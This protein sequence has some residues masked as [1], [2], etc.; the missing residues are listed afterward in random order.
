[1]WKELLPLRAAFKLEPRCLHGRQRQKLT[2]YAI[3]AAMVCQ[4]PFASLVREMIDWPP[5]AA[6]GIGSRGDAFGT[7][8]NA[9]LAN[10]SGMTAAYWT[11]ALNGL[12]GR[13]D[14]KS[15]TWQPFASVLNDPDALIDPSRR[16]CPACLQLDLDSGVV[17]Y[18]R[19]LWTIRV[20]R[21]CPEHGQTLI[22]T[23][24]HC[25]YR[26][27]SEMSRRAV[28]GMCWRCNEWLG[29]VAVQPSSREDGR[30]TNREIWVAEQI[31]ALLELDGQQTSKV[32]A[33]SVPIMLDCGVSTFCDGNAARFAK[34]VQRSASSLSEWRAGKVIPSLPTLIELA[35]ACDVSLR[36]WF[37]GD[38]VAWQS[39]V[40][41]HLGR[42]EWSKKRMVRASIVQRDWVSI[43]ARIRQ[44]VAVDHGRVVSWRTVAR[45][46]GVDQC[47]L[48]RRFP[49]EAEVISK[50]FVAYRSN[51]A[52]Q[53]RTA[54]REHLLN[55]F[56]AA[57]SELIASGER[58]TRR[59]IQKK[60]TC[61][62][63]Q[64]RRSDYSWIQEQLRQRQ[65]ITDYQRSGLR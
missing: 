47:E 18:E 53:R 2:D 62:G 14:L 39:A 34:L 28:S 50:R 35:W 45:E 16:W 40:P 23:C 29:D 13:D 51:L 59:S 19:L 54:G 15:L 27:R 64:L 1:M 5:R 22:D 65:G 52:Q 33:T 56:Q 49:D 21:C 10:A 48:R 32:S 61:A 3:H 12:S 4:V 55:M 26:H 60:L 9:A 31:S 38:L 36:A 11:G 63:I 41:R 43:Q 57:R 25:G 6:R 58:V 24:S 17:P 20:V 46:A 30:A 37:L 7:A 8:Q 42:D 44:H